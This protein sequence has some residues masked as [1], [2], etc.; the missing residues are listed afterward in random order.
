MQIYVIFAISSASELTTGLV[1]GMKQPFALKAKHISIRHTLP[2][3]LLR[4]DH[5]TRGIK[6]WLIDSETSK[7]TSDYTNIVYTYVCI[8]MHVCAYKYVHVSR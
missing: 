1:M 7:V 5:N 8:G 6:R 3:L 2:R 4:R